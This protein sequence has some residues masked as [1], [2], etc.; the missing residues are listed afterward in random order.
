MLLPRTNDLVFKMLFVQSIEGL[1]GMLGAVL[2]TQVAS[3]TILNPEIPGLVSGDGADKSIVLDVRVEL[4]DGSRVIVEMQMRASGA[5][6]TRLAFYAAR[7]LSASMGRGQSYDGLT[8]TV[9]IVWLG[10][11]LFPMLP[12]SLH[13]IFELREGST[14]ELLTDRLAIH[15]LQLEDF[16]EKSETLKLQ[17][18]FR[19]ARF[20]VAK[21]EAELIELANGDE[22]M[23]DAVET[24]KHLSQD[25]QAIRLAQEREDELHLYRHELAVSRREG[26]AEGQQEG[27]AEGKAELLRALLEAK[28]GA[29]TQAARTRLAGATETD[30]D[31]WTPR[32]LSANT[33]SDVF[34]E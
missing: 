27:R 23:A 19:W 13:R 8:P 25:R 22:Q 14:G 17:P 15:V 2:G 10:Q 16:A 26:R 20:F 12:A 28:F 24:I 21:D 4:S 7:D 3:L 6:A 32:V 11:R 34:A 9:L 33:P 18:L 31:L 30:L 1:K 29:L 5:L